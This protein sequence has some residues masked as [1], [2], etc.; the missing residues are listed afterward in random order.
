MRRR[1]L[2]RHGSN[3]RCSVGTGCGTGD[4]CGRREHFGGGL[5]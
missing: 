4:I 1:G 2:G 5:R 3:K